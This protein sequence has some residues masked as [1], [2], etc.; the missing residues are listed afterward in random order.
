MEVVLRAGRRRA[1]PARRGRERRARLRAQLPA[2]ARA[3]RGRRRP[4]LDARARA[5]RRAAGAPRGEDGRRGAR[6]RRRGSR[7]SSSAS[8]STPAPPARCSARSPRRTSPTGSGSRRSSASTAAS[9]RWTTIKRIGRY[10]VPFEVFP[11]VVA[12]LKL[13]VAPEG[14]ELPP[15]GGA[16]RARGRGGCGRGRSRRASRRRGAHAAGGCDRSRRSDGG[17]GGRARRRRSGADG[18]CRRAS[19]SPSPSDEARADGLSTPSTGSPPAWG[20]RSDRLS[21]RPREPVDFGRNFPQ[22][23][24]VSSTTA[25]ANILFYNRLHDRV[26]PSY[27]TPRLSTPFRPGREAAVDYSPVWPCLPRRSATAPIPPQNLDAEE[28]VLGAMMLSPLAIGA[29]TESTN[30]SAADFYRE[31]HGQIYQASSRSTRRASRSTRS[32]SSTS[33]TARR[34]L[35]EVGGQE[36]VHELA[37]LVPA[38]SNAAHYARIVSEMATLRGLI[39]AGN[40]IARLG[41]DRPG[42]T[43]ELVDRAESDRLQPLAAARLERVRAHRRPAQGLVRDDHRSS[44]RPAATSPARRPG[45]AT[46]TGSPPA[47]SRAT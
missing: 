47:S 19:S 24:S 11:D 26:P 43:V 10:T 16:R 33:S 17:R 36:R 7:R 8:T 35:D 22:R 31:S 18:A 21:T 45:S 34:Q 40:D 42:E 39:R 12:E 9:C 23:P 1:R 37:T 38:A 30:L 44:T 20:Q 25:T 41:F 14:E 32:P 4:A 5:A 28:S 15:G 3:R 46:S 13:V 6:D 2:A 29:V 27:S